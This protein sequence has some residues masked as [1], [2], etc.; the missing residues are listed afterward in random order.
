LH[1]VFIQI[2][3]SYVPICPGVLITVLASAPKTLPTVLTVLLLHLHTVIAIIITACSAGIEKDGH[4]VVGVE[5]AVINMAG[6]GDT[7]A[8]G[9]MDL[10]VAGGRKGMHQCAMQAA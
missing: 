1:Q 7:M 6:L 8:I 3:T 4:E 9:Q 2:Y 5:G 10:L